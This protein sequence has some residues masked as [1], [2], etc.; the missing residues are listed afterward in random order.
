[1]A[2]QI[3]EKVGWKNE[4]TGNTPISAENLEHMDSALK[5]LYDEGAT[6]KDIFICGE[7]QT[8]DDAP[9]EAKII[10]CGN[11]IY[12]QNNGILSELLLNSSGDEFPIGFYAY[13]SGEQIPTNWLRCDGQEV[14]RTD[15]SELFDAIGTTYGSGDGST[16]FNLPNVNLEH[17][18]LVGSSGDGEFSVGNTG[19]EKE[20]AL[21]AEENGP[22][23]H[24]LTKDFLGYTQG[25]TNGINSQ[26]QGPWSLTNKTTASSGNGTPHNNMQ[27]FIAA[28]CCIK[29]KRNVN[30]VDNSLMER[31]IFVGGKEDAP[32]GTK[33]IIEETNNNKSA[34]GAKIILTDSIDSSVKNL[35]VN[36]YTRQKTYSG[37]NLL[38]NSATTTTLNGLTFT[39]NKDGS[40][41]IKG[42]S[43][44][45]T[46]LNINENNTITLKESVSY[47]LSKQGD[48]QYIEVNLRKKS[49]NE[50]I[51]SISAT[52]TTKTFINT[53]TEPVF[54]YIGI[55]SNVTLDVTIS[56]QI[57]EGTQATD[58]EPYVGGIP[59]PNLDYPQDIE[60]DKDNIE[61]KS[62][63]INKFNTGYVTTN[64][65]VQIQ[66]TGLYFTKVWSNPVIESKDIVNVLKPNTTY[67]CYAKSKVISRPQ[68][69][70]SSNHNKVLVLHRENTYGNYERTIIQIDKTKDTEQETI[71]TFTTPESL[72]NVTMRG[73]T[74]HGN[75]NGSTTYEKIGEIEISDLMILEGEYTKENIP[76][77]EPYKDSVITYSLGNNFMSDRD[78]VKNGTLVKKFEKVLL[79]GSEDISLNG[80]SNGIYQYKIPL[81]DA[82]PRTLNAV[83]IMSNH[84]ITNQSS[85]FYKKDGVITLVG[86]G[87][88]CVVTTSKYQTVDSFKAFLQSHQVEIY[89]E[90]STPKN[91]SLSSVGELRTFEPNTII[92]N[93]L[94]SDM[95]IDYAISPNVKMY[96]RN[97]KGSFNK[98][99][100]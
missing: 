34:N 16:T 70:S 71:F 37:K 36:G 52:N 41:H 44:S 14:S 27:P 30:N 98:I 81:Q 57:K 74:F 6:S 68:Y 80:E 20:H 59:S 62:T 39:I 79:T 8:I 87:D 91:I 3:Y 93:N 47:T 1:M 15:Y 43:T 86:S 58:C 90:I 31:E 76:K 96:Y 78:Y 24:Q 26:Q 29:A 11:K 48:N 40:I 4:S 55:A 54:V 42:T 64:N 50:S 67:T 45:R 2:K 89:Y 12:I 56:L 38:P 72:D 77:Y 69:T 18:T 82:K 32:T 100:M 95:E 49:V 61:V 88:Y 5:Y 22:H 66:D 23:N 84:F 10:I 9:E 21:T 60:V 73:Y 65:A 99:Y 46:L 13:F 97:S 19:G 28:V 33:L 63:G 75:N 53:Y 83:E 51:A 85:D 92:T 35:K 17:R 25:Q 94:N 7:G